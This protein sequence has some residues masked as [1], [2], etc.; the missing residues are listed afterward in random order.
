M[1]PGK[2]MLGVNNGR[3]LTYLH[4]TS[5]INYEILSE[6]TRM[7]FIKCHER[8]KWLKELVVK[9]DDLRFI[10]IYMKGNEPRKNGRVI[11]LSQATASS[12]LHRSKS[13]STLRVTPAVDE[14]GIFQ[15]RPK[16]KKKKK[17]VKVRN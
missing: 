16:S 15:G 13:Q 17:R 2:V 1:Y 14:I 3:E 12:L 10:P 5:P 7:A 11:D 8:I 9:N 6:A 4:V